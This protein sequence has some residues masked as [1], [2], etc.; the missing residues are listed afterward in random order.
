MG[1]GN[2]AWT[3]RADPIAIHLDRDS[4]LQKRDGYTDSIADSHLHHNP[5][6]PAK[7]PALQS[8]SLTDRQRRPRHYREARTN[9]ELYRGYFA[10]ID[11]HGLVP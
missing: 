7:R 5:F 9:H 4:S 10:F 2:P 8:N 3:E 1:W 11:W 6:Q